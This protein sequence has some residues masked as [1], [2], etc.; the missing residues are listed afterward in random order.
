MYLD[1]SRSF[2]LGE[3]DRV[4]SV[5]RIGIEVEEADQ[6]VGKV[7]P[8]ELPVVGSPYHRSRD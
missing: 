6:T 4:C 2:E 8:V 3:E 5:D 7:S 1:C